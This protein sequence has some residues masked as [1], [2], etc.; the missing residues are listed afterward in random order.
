MSIQARPKPG[1]IA[2][3]TLALVASLALTA[4]IAGNASALSVS[5]E[6]LFST[7][8]GPIQFQTYSGT[9]IECKTMQNAF[10][11]KT[12]ATIGA[13]GS[14]KFENCTEMN[15]GFKFTCS[16]AGQPTGTIATKNLEAELVYLNAAKT[17]FGLR[18][19]PTTGSIVAEFGCPGA[20]TGA[21]WTGSSLLGE[22][23]S[24]GLNETST[25]FHLDFSGSGG[26][27]KYVQVEETGPVY[28][29]SQVTNGKTSPMSVNFGADSTSWSG[30]FSFVP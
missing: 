13:S 24:P 11:F 23:T 17:R 19:T 20:F 27:Q 28:Q 2:R 4:L 29:L 21:T 26:V 6:T 9:N 30:T 15:T 8:G 16:T 10:L 12:G 22:I 25:T 7:S 1:R 14:S 5:K 18:L 3:F